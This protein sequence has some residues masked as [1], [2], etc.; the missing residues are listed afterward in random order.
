[1]SL[2][3]LLTNKE[4]VA[5]YKDEWYMYHYDGDGNRRS[6]DEIDEKRRTLAK[7]AEIQLTQS[8]KTIDSFNEMTLTRSCLI[9]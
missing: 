9:L 5:R 8:K 3:P 1:M 4:I 7:L 2:R 6:Q